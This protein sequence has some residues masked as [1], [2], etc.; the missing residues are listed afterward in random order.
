MPAHLD[1]LIIW[2]DYATHKGLAIRAWLENHPWFHM[3]FTPTYSSWLNEVERLFGLITQD[4]LQRSDPG[5]SEPSR[6][7]SASRSTAGTRTPGR[8][9]RPRPPSRFSAPPP[10]NYSVLAAEDSSSGVFGVLPI[11]EQ[12][13]P[14]QSRRRVRG[15]RRLRRC[16]ALL[17]C[18]QRRRR[19]AAARRVP[20]RSGSNGVR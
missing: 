17:P 7:T 16:V 6:R 15:P 8:P 12:V 4:P 10:G 1:A 2:D 20:Q 5:R 19:P 18:P 9:P 11:S 3:H 14:S 13:G